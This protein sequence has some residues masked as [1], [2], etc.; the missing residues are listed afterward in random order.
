[1]ILLFL[2]QFKNQDIRAFDVVVT[3]TDR[4]K[5]VCNRCVIELFVALFSLSLCPFD[6]SVSVWAFVIGL[7]QTSSFFF[8]VDLVILTQFNAVLQS[9]N[10]E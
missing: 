3:P 2:V 4:P 1:M 8:C 10:C 6:I 7:S 9:V 5:S